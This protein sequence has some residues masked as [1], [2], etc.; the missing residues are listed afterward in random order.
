MPPTNTS[1]SRQKAI[2]AFAVVIIVGVIIAAA[3]GMRKAPSDTAVT[4][5]LTSTSAGS[6][7]MQP[8]STDTSSS[9]TTS[10]SYR[11]GTYTASSEYSVPRSYESIGVTLTIKD[12]VVTNAS[13]TNSEGD[14]ESARYQ[15][16]FASVY[17]SYVVGKKVSDIHLSYV[18]GASETTDGF[19][20]ALDQIKQQSQA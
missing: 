3:A 17:R 10:S 15:E 13:I 11:D 7:T 9:P 8:S 1:S 14:R 5:P 20:D 12:S 18:A 16:R 6:T 19:N 4:T 2:T